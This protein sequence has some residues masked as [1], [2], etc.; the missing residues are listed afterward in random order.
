MRIAISGYFGFGNAGDEAVLAAT[1]GE[2]RRRMPNADPVVLSGDPAITEALHDVEAAPRWPLRALLRTIRSSDLLISGG[3][4]LL[5]N[6][7]SLASLGYYLLVLA[8]ARHEGLPYV[9]HAQGLGPLNGW[10]ARRMVR[11]Y[12]RRAEAVTLRDETSL[13]L[14]RQLGAP[15][16]LVSLT[17]DPAFLLEPA[18]GAEIDAILS[19]LGVDARRPLIGMVVREWRAAR[20]AL[21]PLAKIARLGVERWGARTIVMPF[22]LPDDLEVSHE[23]A[24]VAPE[25]ALVDRELHPRA[26][27]GLIGRLDLLVSMRLHALIFAAAT[28]VPAVGLSY[29]PKVEALCEDA[30]QCWA[31][32]TAPADVPALAAEAWEHRAATLSDRQARAGVM[33]ERAGRAFDVIEQV[34]RDLPPA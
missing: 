27:L 3:G 31:P 14:A 19:D 29:D 15:E 20:E 25:V 18:A 17:A 30:G 13:A 33:R 22:H 8:R 26:L 2:L 28:A 23:L 1:L 5:Q 21:G 10:V 32:L 6:A 24:A 7:T 9:I 12:L 34:C 4:S 11:R 16:E